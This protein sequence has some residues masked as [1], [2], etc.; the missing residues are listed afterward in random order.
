MGVEQKVKTDQE[1]GNGEESRIGIWIR[2]MRAINWI[3]LGDFFDTNGV[4]HDCIQDCATLRN[5]RRR[6]VSRK[7]GR[8][9]LLLTPDW[10]SLRWAL[11]PTG[12]DF[13]SILCATTTLYALIILMALVRCRFTANKTSKLQFRLSRSSVPLLT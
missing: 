2:H 9:I 11:S 3:F 1:G 12:R 4:I 7:G 10:G 8:G 13:E 6:V 5:A